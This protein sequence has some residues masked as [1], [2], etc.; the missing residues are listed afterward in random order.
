[1]DLHIEN[2]DFTYFFVCLPE[3][4]LAGAMTSVATSCANAR[5]LLSEESDTQL[6]HIQRC[7]QQRRCGWDPTLG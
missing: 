7:K 5:C 2:C 1:M 3:G 6:T 4:N